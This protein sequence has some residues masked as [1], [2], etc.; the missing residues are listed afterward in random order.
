MLLVCSFF[1]PFVLSN[2]SVSLEFLVYSFFKTKSYGEFFAKLPLSLVFASLP[3]LFKDAVF[4]CM[5][6]EPQY[7]LMF[8]CG[9]QIKLCVVSLVKL[10]SKKKF[11]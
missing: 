4:F 3:Q 7:V 6:F 1:L 2:N 11:S 10:K 9:S 5:Q 8:G